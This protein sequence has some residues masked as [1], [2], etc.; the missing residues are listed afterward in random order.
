MSEKKIP[1]KHTEKRPGRYNPEEKSKELIQNVDKICKMRGISR[2]TLAKGGR[3]INFNN[4]FTSGGQD[5]A[6]YVYG[7]QTVQCTGYSYF[8]FTDR[9]M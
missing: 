4:S 3:Y 1:Q 2:Y 8:R 9:T 7:V 5:K 6:I